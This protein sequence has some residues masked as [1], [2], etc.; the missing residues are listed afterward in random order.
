MQML[1][2]CLGTYVSA[3]QRILYTNALAGTV[4]GQMADEY[5]LGAFV[6]SLQSTGCNP[7]MIPPLDRV[8]CTRLRRRWVW[9]V[10]RVTTGRLCGRGQGGEWGGG[11]LYRPPDRKLTRKLPQAA[12]CSFLVGFYAKF[13][14]AVAPGPVE[15]SN[16]TWLVS[17]IVYG[18][19][20]SCVDA[21]TAMALTQQPVTQLR[22]PAA[23]RHQQRNMYVYHIHGVGFFGPLNHCSAGVIACN[24][25]AASTVFHP[26][27]LPLL[28]QG[29][30]STGHPV[31]AAAVRFMNRLKASRQLPAA[32]VLPCWLR[33]ITSYGSSCRL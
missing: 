25:A 3:F 14:L 12:S 18:L 30:A 2:G 10:P 19:Q 23:N 6:E 17:A 7:L 21:N 11:P 24:L 33:R 8:F 16:G 20:H 27:P 13:A 28:V 32:Q 26:K 4:V 29:T 5:N 22:E 9:W 15:Y 31:S 1:L